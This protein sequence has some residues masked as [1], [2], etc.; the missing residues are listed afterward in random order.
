MKKGNEKKK[1]NRFLSVNLS[2]VMC[3]SSIPASYTVVAADEG[4]ETEPGTGSE[5]YSVCVKDLFGENVEGAQVGLSLSL[6]NGETIGVNLDSASTDA[7]GVVEIQQ[8]DIKAALDAWMVDEEI[9]DEPVYT[10]IYTASKDGYAAG[11]SVEVT[12][13]EAYESGVDL[14]L[15]QLCDLKGTLDFIGANMTDFVPVYS[16]SYSFKNIE[17]YLQKDEDGNPIQPELETDGTNFTLKNAPIS[18][19]EVELTVTP[20]EELEVPAGSEYSSYRQTTKT[21]ELNSQDDA[22]QHLNLKVEPDVLRV[23]FPSSGKQG[24]FSN[25]GVLLE[26]RDYSPEDLKRNKKISF[27]FNPAEGMTLQKMELVV[28]KAEDDQPSIEEVVN[29]FG[30]YSLNL[31]NYADAYMIRIRPVMEDNAAPFIST[32]LMNNA[33]EGKYVPEQG[34]DITVEE[35]VSETVTV[36]L[37]KLIEGTEDSEPGQDEVETAVLDVSEGQ[38]SYHFEIKANATYWITATDENNN[39]SDTSAAD[40]DTGESSYIK[41]ENLDDEDPVSSNVTVTA[42]EGKDDVVV[43]FKAMDPDNSDGTAGSGIRRAQWYIQNDLRP[44]MTDIESE[45]GSYEFR[46]PK[47]SLARCVVVLE[48]GAGR[49]DRFSPDTTPYLDVSVKDANVWSNEKVISYTLKNIDSLSDDS[50][51]SIILHNT[52][53]NGL[54]KDVCKI[55][56][57]ENGSYKLKTKNLKGEFTY[58]GERRVYGVAAAGKFTV[59]MIISDENGEISIQE[60][61]EIDHLDVAKPQLIIPSLDSEGSVWLN[62]SLLLDVTADDL[63]SGVDRIVVSRKSVADSEFEQISQ[64]SGFADPDQ[65]NLYHLS[66]A[67][68]GEKELPEDAEFKVEVFDK[69]GNSAEKTVK[70]KSDTEAPKITEWKYNEDEY[71]FFCYGESLE[72]TVEDDSEDKIEVK[73][74]T[75]MSGQD[76]TKTTILTPDE[77]NKCVFE[78]SPEYFNKDVFGRF[79][80]TLSVVLTDKAG[81][82]ETYILNKENKLVMAENADVVK[83]TGITYKFV[84]KVGV[85]NSEPWLRGDNTLKID[86]ALSKGLFTGEEADLE[87]L[88]DS[89]SIEKL[90]YQNGSWKVD[91]NSQPIFVENSHAEVLITDRTDGLT[92]DQAD[93]DGTIVLNAQNDIAPDGSIRIRLTVKTKF[94]VEKS[95]EITDKKFDSKAPQINIGEILKKEYLEDRVFEENVKDEMQSDVVSIEENVELIGWS[96]EFKG[97]FYDKGGE[98]LNNGKCSIVTENPDSNSIHLSTLDPLEAYKA[99]YGVDAGAFDGTATIKA[100]DAAGNKNTIAT[101]KFIIDTLIPENPEIKGMIGDGAEYLDAVNAADNEGWANEKVTLLI[102]AKHVPSGIQKVEITND[103][104]P[105]LNKPFDYSI[106]RESNEDQKERDKINYEACEDNKAGIEHLVNKDSY[107]GTFTVKITTFAGKTSTGTFTV[108]QDTT[109]PT[110][111][112]IQDSSND[113]SVAY[114]LKTQDMDLP[115]TY[116]KFYQDPQEFFFGADFDISGMRSE[117]YKKITSDAGDMEWQNFTDESKVSAGVNERFELFYQAIDNAGNSSEIRSEGVIIDNQEPEISY[118]LP[119]ANKNGFYNSAVTVNINAA[120]PRFKGDVRVNDNDDT[121]V[122]SGLNEVTYTISS[123]STG[124]VETG[125][126]YSYGQENSDEVKLQE[127]FNHLA[128]VMDTAITIDPQKFNANDVV[129]SIT[130]VDNSG[131]TKTVSTEVGDIQIDVTAPTIDVAYDNNNVQNGHYYSADRTATIVITERNFD[132]EDVK[133][134]VTSSNS[135]AELPVLSSWTTQEAGGNQDGTTHTATITYHDDADYTFNIEYTDLADNAASGVNYAEGTNNPTEFTVDQTKPVIKVEYDNNDARNGNFYKASR[136]ATITV[137]EHNFDSEKVNIDIK[138]VKSDLQGSESSVSQPS[139]SS[140]NTAGDTHTMLIEYSED[141]DYTFNIKMTDLAEN[142][143]DDVAEQK[144]TVD[145]VFDGFRVVINY[146]DSEG[147][148]SHENNDSA[149]PTNEFAYQNLYRILVEYED[150]N[151]RA[152]EGKLEHQTWIDKDKIPE[153]LKEQEVSGGTTTEKKLMRREMQT[154]INKERTSDGI[155]FLNASADDMAGNSKK[156]DLSFSLSKFGS[157]YMYDENLTALQDDEAKYIENVKNNLI[158]TEL[159]PSGLKDD[160]IDVVLSR[161]GNVVKIIE[162]DKIIESKEEKSG[163]VTEEKNNGLYATDSKWYEYKHVISKNNFKNEGVYTISLSSTDQAGTISKNTAN[164]TNAIDKDKKQVTPEIEFYVDKYPPTLDFVNGI[165]SDNFN[166]SERQVSYSVSDSI[167]LKKVEV[168]SVNAKTGKEEML[169]THEFAKGEDDKNFK[170]EVTVRES[171][172]RQKL[173]IVVTDKAGHV[174]NSEE[175]N[176]NSEIYPNEF[177]MSTNWWVLFVNNKPLFYGT[178]AALIAIVAGGAG[179]FLIKNRRNDEDEEDQDTAAI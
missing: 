144:F 105:D 64:V 145:K 111:L 95:I 66:M 133:L 75:A 21:F 167:G 121:G 103:Q 29:R 148:K 174:T 156:A 54:I 118:E 20:G 12:S 82:S 13:D 142:A 77:N 134:T 176:A 42:E 127:E 55:Y 146:G 38:A 11:D 61:V 177:V 151:L 76:E 14:E 81:N 47:D 158:I 153:E 30:L 87:S 154:S 69:A 155:Y 33:D 60:P 16:I 70:A 164:E 7:D 150:I 71:L 165:D 19:G 107:N 67:K 94:N 136:T 91:E 2:L 96:V 115:K 34:I 8:A 132:P 114:E 62:E 17:K 10:M 97:T 72:F 89:I 113:S 46:V 168:Y 120:D 152:G 99:Q 74:L 41:I 171:S 160:T 100:T 40:P 172:Q 112:K 23:S 93:V 57:G 79:H 170:G 58:K 116:T 37:W 179:Y 59:E 166:A 101:N 84:P 86:A 39:T 27:K 109:P 51:I 36:T 123:A 90:N 32:S 125:T 25:N 50:E 26:D 175:V 9:T 24:S 119:A 163:P 141:A 178:L 122:F 5:S 104:D 68:D 162:D 117:H 102:N 92:G 43:S 48:D 138:A 124:A 139:K 73:I 159:N 56:D 52:S 126:L 6:E 147:D 161:D 130:A 28:Y 169:D 157:L 137:T 106:N 140:W 3:L 83:N 1:L 22:K 149:S 53:T 65:G 31:A 88:I 131:N 63:K 143:N 110:D 45:D 15:A 108:K 80:G 78:F 35:A 98:K 4:D 85:K 173:H 44:V 18:Q 129:L 135:S 49:Q 128:R